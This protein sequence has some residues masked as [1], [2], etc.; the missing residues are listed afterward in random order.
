MHSLLNVNSLNNL[1][2]LNNPNHKQRALQ[3]YN[4]FSRP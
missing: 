3:V 1:H 4:A 2:D